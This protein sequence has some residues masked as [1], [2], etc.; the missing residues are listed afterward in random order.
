MAAV[1]QFDLVQASNGDMQAADALEEQILRRL[2]VER[3]SALE[4]VQFG[5][6][7]YELR[8]TR[9]SATTRALAEAYARD[10]LAPLVANGTLRNL[11]VAVEL[12]ASRMTINVSAEA[13]NRKP[14][15]VTGI[16]EW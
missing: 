6:R 4:D 12:S 8:R 7:L 2:A 9:A 15:T 10:A 11:K 16:V 1:L 14:V 13:A 5:S 3:G